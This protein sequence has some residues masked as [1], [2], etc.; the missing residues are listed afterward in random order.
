MGSCA[1]MVRITV[2]VIRKRAEH[3]EGCL[4]T[5]K[6]V[7]LHQHEIEKIENLD[8][9]CRRLQIL[10]LQGNVIGKIENL[11]RLREL[12][13]LNLC[14][15]NVRKIENLENNEAL[16][17]LDLTCNFVRDPLCIENLKANKRLEELYLIGNPITDDEDYRDFTIA[18]L[19][20]L[21]KLD[22]TDIERSERIV[23]LQRL[24]AIRARYVEEA[25]AF[26]EDEE[27]D[28]EEED[29]DGEE[30]EEEDEEDDEPEEGHQRRSLPDHVSGGKIDQFWTQERE[31]FYGGKFRF[32]RNS[33]EEPTKGM[34]VAVQIDLKEFEPT[35]AASSCRTMSVVMEGPLVAD[36]ES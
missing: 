23:A 28:D 3:N 32:V 10:Y 16:E 24:P 20:Q 5:L 9:L 26:P 12:N 1:S 34:V 4:S 22:G 6:E 25:A 7:T 36:A 14:L 19:P 33:D 11:G 13:Y 31:K 15:N 27:D 17:K 18:T 21:E 8:K 29:A 2:D 30:S 35:M